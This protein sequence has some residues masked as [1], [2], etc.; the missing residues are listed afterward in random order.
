MTDNQ[1]DI[2]RL[3]AWDT[4]DL[5]ASFNSSR[6]IQ[7]ISS[8]PMPSTTNSVVPFSR[9]MQMPSQPIFDERQTQQYQQSKYQPQALETFRPTQTNTSKTR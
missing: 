2:N 7:N 6:S 9:Y 5:P 8:I 4:R 3:T 1:Y